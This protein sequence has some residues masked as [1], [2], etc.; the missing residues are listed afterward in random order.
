MRKIVI[1]L[2]VVA[3]AINLIYWLNRSSHHTATVTPWSTPAT[4]TTMDT[5][6]APTETT[7]E[8]L[9][10]P[11]RISAS[12][13]LI[14]DP[15]IK[16]LFDLLARQN[17]DEPVDQ[18][19]H[20]IL[21]TFA[22]QLPAT[23]L[24]QLQE[25]F[26]RYVEF[27]LALQLLPMEGAPTLQAVLQKVQ[28]LREHYMGDYA[29]PLYADWNALETFTHE[30]LT[31]MT[32]NRDD[33]AARDKLEAMANA[34]PP[35]VQSQALNM[36][37]HSA[38]DFAVDDMASLQPDAYARMLQE[39][40]AVALIETTLLFDEPTP[41]FMAQYEQYS[42]KKRD[43]LLSEAGAAEQQQQLEALRQQYFSGSDI[44]RVETLD[45]AEAY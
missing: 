31:I 7:V 32:Q 26:D 1:M 8:L 5:T 22:K 21:Q 42:E 40:A 37:R 2:V 15:R 14:P 25:A 4:D 17:S 18:W 16:Q 45:R 43:I 23:A 12:G 35:S 24:A 3:T 19:K 41:A 13:D 34:L 39:Q 44:L 28:S 10:I 30:Y 20:N 11:L 33:S 6:I 38:E 29:A 9:E 27:N 36:I